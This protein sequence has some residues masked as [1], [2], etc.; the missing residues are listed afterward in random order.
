MRSPHPH[1]L[2]PGSQSF[3]TSADD[4]DAPHQMFLTTGKASPGRGG[5]SRR[6]S[7]PPSTRQR[8]APP[9]AGRGVMWSDVASDEGPTGPTLDAVRDMIQGMARKL[10]VG[11][12]ATGPPS[13]HTTASNKMTGTTPMKQLPS[14][15]A[16]TSSDDDD[17]D[18]LHDVG[19][20]RYM[21]RLRL[22]GGHG[23]QP[24][25]AKAVPSAVLSSDPALLRA[26]AAQR[27]HQDSQAKVSAA[28]LRPGSSRPTLAASTAGS[29]AAQRAVQDNLRALSANYRQLRQ[30]GAV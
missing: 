11:S 13:R 30:R 8:W 27:L 15:L 26:H 23:G 22:R 16:S 3:F 19:G 9:A 18:D 20:S 29:G 7:S 17:A 24:Q 21:S 2:S 1:P 25:A 14:R 28:A 10:A 12:R 6:S 5:G 4:L